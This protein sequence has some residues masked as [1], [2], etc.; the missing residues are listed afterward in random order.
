MRRALQVFGLSGLFVTTLAT[1]AVAA[2]TEEADSDAQHN[3]EAPP[4]AVRGPAP[5]LPAARKSAAAASAAPKVGDITTSG[6]F[7]GGF[8]GSNQR[9]RMTCFSLALR[10]GLLS[11]YRLGNE[12]EV[13]GEYHITTVVHAGED[14]SVAH[15]HFMPTAYI[16]NT[17][18]GY[19][20]TGVTSSDKGAPGTGAT[21]AFPNLY[22]DIQGIPWLAGGTAWVGTR[23]YKRES[24]YISDFF[25]WNPSGVGGGIEDIKLGRDLQLSVALFA[26]DGQPNGSPQLPA[27][28]ELGFRGDIQLRGIKFW[29]SGE[30]QAGVQFI[31]D[32]SGETNPEDLDGNG[33]PRPVVTHGGWGGT[34]RYVQQVLGGDNK[35]VVQYG[36]GGGT[37]F[38]TLSRFYY[39]DFSLH[40]DP[41]ESRL[42]VLDVITVQPIE[43]LGL[44]ANVVYQR[45]DTGTGANGAVTQWWS[46]GG[47]ISVGVS[48]HVKLL[49][50]GGYDRVQKSNGSDAQWL[51]KFTLAP[52]LSGGPGLMARP[53]LRLFW[54]YAA[55][56][57]TARTATVDSG[58][59]YT[60]ADAPLRGQIFGMQAET[61]W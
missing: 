20:P 6:Y 44:Q 2:E 48:E 49:A 19:S 11:K 57:E 51:G 12:C 56:N 16:P 24:V 5:V 28:V 17:Y 13:W 32:W 53:E 10:D 9:G 39:P 33:N 40:W 23:Y 8:G 34:V 46:A 43:M 3:T 1:S 59:L 14:G 50:E 61:W 54:T 45:D 26:V 60:G 27:R 47:R 30:F 31:A 7:R 18:I 42:R 29:E 22:A 37:G 25:Y 52:A 15:L 35:F 21:V 4:E 55:W 41:K 36:K 38:G 58:R